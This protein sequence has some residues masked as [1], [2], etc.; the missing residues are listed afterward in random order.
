MHSAAK[1]VHLDSLRIAA[2][3]GIWNSEQAGFVLGATCS[4]V[5]IRKYSQ[6]FQLTRS[7]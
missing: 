6:E 2:G 7:L 1:Y 5:S 4:A 3:L